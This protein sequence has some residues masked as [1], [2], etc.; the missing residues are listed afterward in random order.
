MHHG[1]LRI[2]LI[3]RIVFAASKKL[4]SRCKNT[5]LEDE[6][7]TPLWDGFFVIKLTVTPSKKW[8]NV[9]WKGTILKRKGSSSKHHFC[10]GQTLSFKD[11]T[12]TSLMFGLPE[13]SKPPHFWDRPFCLVSRR[14]PRHGWEWNL[15]KDLPWDFFQG[16]ELDREKRVGNF[17][18]PQV[19]GKSVDFFLF[20]MRTF[21]FEFKVNLG[22]LYQLGTFCYFIVLDFPIPRRPYRHW[23][24]WK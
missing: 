13:I 19:W 6:P 1:N 5:T 22:Y 24:Y 16:W 12:S 7:L 3:F 2:P 8:T 14:S 18:P 11:I 4:T 15:G 17:N 9:P 23:K 21:F 10:F 20:P